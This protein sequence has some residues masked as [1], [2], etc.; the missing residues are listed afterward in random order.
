MKWSRR[1]VL[2]FFLY[3]L[4]TPW[5][6]FAQKSDLAILCVQGISQQCGY[7]TDPMDGVLGKGTKNAIKSFQYNNK[8]A[9]TGIMNESPRTAHPKSQIDT[10]T[11]ANKPSTESAP[12]VPTGRQESSTSEMEKVPIVYNP[13]QRGAPGHRG[14]AAVRGF[15]ETPTFYPLVPDDHIGLTIQEQPALYWYLTEPTTYKIE[16]TIVDVNNDV[17]PLFEHD[18]PSPTR[19]GIQKIDLA[20]YDGV[21]LSLGVHYKWFVSIMPDPSSRSKDFSAFGEI[22]RI[23][24]PT[25][26]VKLSQANKEER[27]AL[28]AEAGLWYDALAAIS[29]LI[30]AMPN[31]SSLRTQRASFLGQIGLREVRE[32]NVK[33]SGE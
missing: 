33:K 13:P 23:E 25:L 26:K 18:L 16:L 21:R 12:A 19:A 6:S 29:D 32:E 10:V 30:D 11:P 24:Q 4:V 8:L 3:E 22:Q 9:Q 15:G 31:D 14:V 1:L 5:L 17:Q 2:G 28:Y 7:E 27:P 20:E